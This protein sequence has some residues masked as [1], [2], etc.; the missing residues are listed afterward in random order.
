LKRQDEILVW[1]AENF[2]EEDFPLKTGRLYDKFG[3]DTGYD[4]TEAAFSELLRKL[5]EKGLVDNPKYGFYQ[6]SEQGWNRAEKLGSDGDSK[7]SGYQAL[8][9]VQE[10]FLNEFKK[11]NVVVNFS[12]IHEFNNDAYDDFTTSPDIFLDAFED[13]MQESHVNFVR[14]SNDVE[15][16]DAE[17]SEVR[18]SSRQGDLV[19]L[20]GNVVEV[21]ERFTLRESVDYECLQCGRV[22]T[23]EN[24]VD[25]IN[26]PDE[27]VCG[28]TTFE[29]KEETL[30]DAKEFTVEGKGKIRCVLHDSTLSDNEL[31][32]ISLGEHL[33]VTGLLDFSD[34]RRSFPYLDLV[35]LRPVPKID[36]HRYSEEDRRKVKEKIQEISQSR[37]PFKI[38]AKSLA[39]DVNGRMDAK[40]VAAA[41]LIGSPKEKISA[42]VVDPRAGGDALVKQI[43]Q[44]FPDG[45][46]ASGSL[47]PEVH[48]EDVRWVETGELLESNH[49]V[50]CVQDFSRLEN[51]DQRMLRSAW[52]TGSFQAHGDSYEVDTDLIASSP[53]DPEDEIFDLV[54]EVQQPGKDDM[55]EEFSED[56]YMLEDELEIYRAVTRGVNP[57][58]SDNARDYLENQ[59]DFSAEEWRILLNL[60]LVFA[61]A[62]L[63]KEADIGDA[64][65]ALGLYE[66]LKTHR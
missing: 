64:E 48:Y 37:N 5:R 29:K 30:T 41:S 34:G 7:P 58:V 31:E 51:E 13:A 44:A 15:A 63:A 45:V 54:C 66:S 10:Q 8:V 49:G 43:S 6:P 4:K 21:S 1:M 24:L 61:R 2:S 46:Y 26:E 36:K 33:K 23:R 56:E 65:D 50:L 42:V 47:K 28:S 32:D 53:T 55:L 27:C 39:P 18:N 3:A 19:S 40:R 60:T 59:R 52:T 35:A 38:F 25:D 12:K 20:K 57:E 17:W 16:F 11:D 62:R 22:F 9:G 14:F